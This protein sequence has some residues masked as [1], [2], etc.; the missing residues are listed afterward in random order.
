MKISNP[1][2]QA[3][4]GDL[5]SGSRASALLKLCANTT[6][7]TLSPCSLWGPVSPPCSLGSVPLTSCVVRC[8]PGLTVC[9]PERTLL[10]SSELGGVPLPGTERL[11]KPPGRQPGPSAPQA[12]FTAGLYHPT[13]QVEDSSWPLA[14]IKRNLALCTA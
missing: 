14:S 1:A 10:L 12:H 2:A 8:S 13:W 4:S 6:L 11:C 5:W 3:S 7:Q 9:E